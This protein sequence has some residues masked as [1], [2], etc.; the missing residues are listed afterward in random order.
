M[1][2]N[3][4][5]QVIAPAEL[6]ADALDGGLTNNQFAQYLR[7]G[8]VSSEL[9]LEAYAQLVEVL[10]RCLDLRTSAISG[11]PRQLVNKETGEIVATANWPQPLLDD[12][13][14]PLTE[15]RLFDQLLLKLDLTDLLWRTELAQCL[16]AQSYWLVQRRRRRIV[17]ARW[18][19]P[20]RVTPQY[21]AQGL[22]YFDY[23]R[24]VGGI[25]LSNDP[26]LVEDVCYIWRPGLRELEP[27]TPPAM[28]AAQ[29][30]GL[31]YNASLFLRVFFANGAM[32]VTVVMSE[33]QPS[34]EE[35]NRLKMFLGRMMRG[36]QNAFNIEVVS[37]LLKFEK[38]TPN[39]KDLDFTNMASQKE[40]SI[41]VAMGVPLS[42][43]FS[44]V[45]NYAGSS[46]KDD[47]HF[48]DKTIV[49][50]AQFLARIINRQ[51]FHPLGL[52]L[53]FRPDLLEVYQQREM[54]KVETAIQLFDRRV[55]DGNELRQAA[56]YEPI[57]DRE[58]DEMA[59][60]EPATAVADDDEDNNEPPEDDDSQDAD[61][62]ADLKR[63][64]RKVIKALKQGRDPTA[65][66]F[67][68]KHLSVWETDAIQQA[69]AT[70]TTA[71]EVKAVMA[72]PFVVRRGDWHGPAPASRANR[73][74]NFKTHRED[75][76]ELGKIERTAVRE[77]HDGLQAQLAA[78]EAQANELGARNIDALIV[79]MVQVIDEEKGELTGATQRLIY[80]ST[81]RGATAVAQVM[82][83]TLSMLVDW[84][85]MSKE[86]FTFSQT[87]SFD[88]VTDLNK[89]T[90][91]G[92]RYALETWI[93]EGGT[94]D[95]LTDSIRPIFANEEAT[96]RIEALFGIDRARLIATTEATR[97]YAQG[98]VDAWMASGEAEVPPAKI[99]PAHPGCRC[100]ITMER[101]ADGSWRWRW[102]TARDDRVCPICSPYQL[103]PYLGLARRSPQDIVSNKPLPHPSQ[104]ITM[105]ESGVASSVRQAIL[106]EDERIFARAKEL[107]AEMATLRDKA[108][109]IWQ[110]RDEWREMTFPD[111]IGVP[112]EHRERW[113]E[114]NATYDAI[115]NSFYAKQDEKASILS[116]R[117]KRL[118]E[119]LYVDAP[120]NVEINLLEGLSKSNPMYA[121]I[122][123]GLTEF[124]KLVSVN[125][126]VDEG[127][128]P[129]VVNKTDTGRA[130][131]WSAKVYLDEA[132]DASVFVHEMGHWLEDSYL[133][134]L[135]EAL[136]F[137]DRR[138]LGEQVTTLN[139]IYGVSYY[140][141]DEVTK[142]DNFVSPYMGKVYESERRGRYATE[143]V[144]MGLEL[145]YRDPHTLASRDPE[146]FDFIYDLVR[147]RYDQ[148]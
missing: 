81:E 2:K 111:S 57:E 59:E 127:T 143:I 13:N 39:I 46:E 32:P 124:R 141:N 69:L 115:W 113:E 38:L 132:S 145:F 61:R 120:T 103:S 3:M 83:R 12:D 101:L 36:V 91:R 135:E 68:S 87:Y 109:K 97:A 78:L 98:K 27:G 144:S 52:S 130:F 29:A 108:N 33:D 117:A 45:G 107:D 37:S 118:R 67:V 56:G 140:D 133:E 35:R 5:L 104:H 49:P 71:E 100:D 47:L 99:P 21:N 80:A 138:T 122:E 112:N 20:V 40:K 79:Q 73:K 131:Y 110:E 92:L 15:E 51:F 136:D 53:A 134:I 116:N 95:D 72:R 6:K 24:V 121:Q 14:T 55:I 96:R 11:L 129:V 48:Y 7:E 139:E 147:G 28:A 76:R 75:D 60:P 119:F 137:Y 17:G 10:F 126:A 142:V 146:Y 34:P 41:A 23:N 102:D 74:S 1:T 43:L 82:P 18:M 62:Q 94:L 50:Q 31:V 106:A 77:I 123:E 9:P 30:A 54:L 114:Y 58:M 65:V 42:V 66:S 25:H 16:L 4:K 64:E 85:M 22:W 93:E 148:D 70:A 63:W 89:T 8:A 105:P 84:Q 128:W 19:D 125:A 88:L 44:G 86:A 90:E 26:V